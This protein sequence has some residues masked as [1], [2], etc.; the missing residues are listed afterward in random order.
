MSQGLIAQT[1]RSFIGSAF[2]V[3]ALKRLIHSIPIFFAIIS[4]N[5]LLIH[6]AP[7]DPASYLAGQSQGSVEY[8]TQLRKEF[9]L[10]KP[11]IV[12]LGIYLGKVVTGDLG[13]SY[14]YQQPVA[15]LIGSRLGNTLL[16]LGT[17]YFLATVI[18]VLLGA[19]AAQRANSVAD[20]ITSF[21][22]LA[23][24]SMPVF[25]LGQLALL[26]FA[27]ELGWFP[28]QGMVNLRLAATGWV[29]VVD[30]AHHLVLPATTYAVYQLTLMYRLARSKLHEVLQEDYITTARAKGLPER[31]VVYRH[32]L[33]NAL[34]PLVTVL[35][36]DFAFM[37]AG[38]VLVE[39]VFAWPGMG[40]LMFEAIAARD[41]PILTG[42]FTVVTAMVIIVNI[43]TDL[44][45][46]WIDPRVVYE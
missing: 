42:I 41:Y 1:S 20:Q 26:F 15:E 39:T 27:L 29:K 10:D 7:G 35:G 19:F 11:L 33:R 14:R 32:G 44:I 22:A 6:L 45:Y 28:T 24:Y 4:I 18:G 36:M 40:R 34:L 3:V 37:L 25:W 2:G 46:A 13:M 23:C 30:V 31:V 17:G 5:F 38:T 21:I 16:L 9:G 8:Q 12:Q 43:I